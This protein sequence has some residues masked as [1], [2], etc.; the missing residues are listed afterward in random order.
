MAP[1]ALV[2]TCVFWGL[3]FPLLKALRLEQ[4]GRLIGVPG[5]FLTA[6]V[7]IARFGLGAVLL[8]P[9]VA[10][11]PRPTR[12]EVIQGAKLA[13]W[14]GVGMGIQA[15]GL[16]YTQAST[17]AF[18]TQAYCVLL[19]L[20]A[21]VQQ[22]KPPRF[23]VVG[24]TVL[25]AVGGAVLAGIGWN[26][27]LG[28]GEVETLIAALLFTFQILTLESPR[29]AANRSRPVTLIM[30]ALVAAIFLPVAV[31]LAPS[32][33]AFVVAGASWPAVGILAGIWWFSRPSVDSS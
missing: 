11:L 25:V 2:L 29:Y 5:E 1:L 17:S 16:A 32:P 10:R 9:V 8:V 4:E 15:D 26:L 7:Q 30:C 33:S 24:A 20:W 14:G 6:W 28:R 27:A 21:A 18:L 31:A 22:R 12:L 23:K 13:L 19:P 3:S